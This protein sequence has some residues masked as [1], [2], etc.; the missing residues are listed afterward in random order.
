M[1]G[2]ARGAVRAK[3]IV[4]VIGSNGNLVYRSRERKIFNRYEAWLSQWATQKDNR[5]LWMPRGFREGKITPV[6][7]AFYLYLRLFRK[8]VY[9][10]L[11]NG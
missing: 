8:S 3:G 9:R 1:Q 7:L 10:R 2:L 5:K 4:E 11:T 6:I